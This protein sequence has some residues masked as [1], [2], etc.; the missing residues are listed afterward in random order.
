[1]AETLRSYLNKKLRVTVSD[2]RV[3]LGK[4]LC[5]D[6][7]RNLVVSSCL[8]Y[9]AHPNNSAGR[10][11]YQNDQKIGR[12]TNRL[13]TTHEAQTYVSDDLRFKF[14]FFRFECKAATSTCWNGYYT[15]AAYNEDRNQGK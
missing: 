3:L 15:R 5:T 12:R 8:E 9:M 13:S 7:D 1:M 11:L 6:R 14:S 10:H 4:L 2:G